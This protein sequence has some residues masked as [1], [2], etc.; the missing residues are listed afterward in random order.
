MNV[1]ADSTNAVPAAVSLEAIGRLLE[2]GR[3][4][5]HVVAEPDWPQWR[6]ASAGLLMRVLTLGE[7]IVH[8]SELRRVADLSILVR[9]LYDHAVMLAWISAPRDDSRFTVWNR[10]SLR[11]VR[12]WGNEMKAMEAGDITPE[13]R[14][15]LE[16]QLSGPGMPKTRELA[17]QADRDWN[18]RLG[19]S[20]LNT[21][22]ASYTTVFRAGSFFAHP[23]AAG[24]YEN[25][26]P[27]GDH[28]VLMIEPE[29]DISPTIGCVFT[30]LAVALGVASHTIGRPDL[31]AIKR[32]VTECADAAAAA[33]RT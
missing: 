11:I 31:Y 4:I 10:E 12:A 22:T 20:G 16:E 6:T 32:I 1:G 29:G 9:C 5:G 23:T 26:R 17:R 30:F 19:L 33:R 28:V 8:V 25:R 24:L 3:S 18:G 27:A 7:T 21:L 2:L 14:E 13:G 15:W